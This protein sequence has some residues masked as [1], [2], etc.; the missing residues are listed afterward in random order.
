MLLTHHDCLHTKLITLTLL[1]CSDRQ[2]DITTGALVKTT[3]TFCDTQVQRSVWPATK[4]S[5]E[6][7]SA[8]QRLLFSFFHRLSIWLCD[9]KASH[10]T[11]I[12]WNQSATSSYLPTY[13]CQHWSDSERL[14]QTVHTSGNVLAS[15]LTELGHWSR[16][17][18]LFW[19]CQGLT[20]NIR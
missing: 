14:T 17:P 9:W 10:V 15:T 19:H 1:H 16:P 20:Y 6:V 7:K 5:P 2:T 8:D 11:T 18:T 4:R 13:N 3:A 12:R